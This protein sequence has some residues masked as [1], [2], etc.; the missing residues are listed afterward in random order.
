MGIPE[1]EES[2]PQIKNLFEEIM[3]DK[4]VQT[5]WKTL[6]NFL[7]NL[8]MELPFDLA[9]PLLNP[10]VVRILKHQSKRTYALQCS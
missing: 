8:N 2:E 4:L 1:G 9:I 7:R 10:E 6:W 3:T 5:L